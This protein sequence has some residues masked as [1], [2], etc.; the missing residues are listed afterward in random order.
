VREQA[1]EAIVAEV[2]ARWSWQGVARSIVAA[3]EG[4][5]DDLPTP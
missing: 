4:R 3:A 5:L 2:R 1:R